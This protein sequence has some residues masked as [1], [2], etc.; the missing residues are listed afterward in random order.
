MSGKE[1]NK[2]RFSEIDSN[3]RED[4]NKNVKTSHSASTSLDDVL[5]KKKENQKYRKKFDG[6]K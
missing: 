3:V 1:R 4:Y 2:R 5:P 6:K